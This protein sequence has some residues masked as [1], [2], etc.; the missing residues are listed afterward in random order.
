MC[1]CSLE[2]RI[3]RMR[4]VC[5]GPAR[6][7]QPSWGIS[8]K[9][10]SFCFPQIAVPSSR[11]SMDVF[12]RSAAFSPASMHAW[13][14]SANAYPASIFRKA[15][16]PAFTHVTLHQPSQHLI[17]QNFTSLFTMSRV[18][19]SKLPLAAYFSLA[20]AISLEPVEHAFQIGNVPCKARDT[21]SESLQRLPTLHVARSHARMPVF[22]LP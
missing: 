22:S 2:A 3:A 19:N 14:L 4:C 5:G 6:Y 16:V 20:S 21:N 15:S 9:A 11:G 17:S 10:R 1:K 13:G 12:T 8:R 18:L 7:Q